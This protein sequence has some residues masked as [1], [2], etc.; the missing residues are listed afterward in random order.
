MGTPVTNAKQTKPRKAEHQRDPYR[1]PTKPFGRAAPEFGLMVS[2]SAGSIVSETDT[3][4]DTG[5]FPESA[6]VKTM[7]IVVAAPALLTCTRPCI[8]EVTAVGIPETIPVLGSKVKP[9]GNVPDLM[10]HV[11]GG[12]PPW[13]YCVRLS[14]KS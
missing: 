9:A 7:M 2:G 8:A 14:K 10:L 1:A 3:L 6:A 11:S 4:T 12:V 13:T 5:G